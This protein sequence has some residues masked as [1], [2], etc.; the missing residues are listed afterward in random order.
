MSFLHG[1]L[2][3]PYQVSQVLYSRSSTGCVH[4]KFPHQ[5][6]LFELKPVFLK[7]V[8]VLIWAFMWQRIHQVPRYSLLLLDYLHSNAHKRFVVWSGVGSTLGISPVLTLLNKVAQFHHI[9][10]ILPSSRS[11]CPLISL[12][13]DLDWA[14]LVSCHKAWLPKLM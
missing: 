4:R 2:I 5:A 7:D 14:S 13:M 6:T 11:S 3:C 8:W 12:R 1:S 9:S 10:H